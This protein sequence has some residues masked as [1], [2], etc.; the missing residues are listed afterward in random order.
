MQKVAMKDGS[1][2]VYDHLNQCAAGSLSYK[3]GIA[4]FRKINA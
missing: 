4:I 3:R 1:A 2:W